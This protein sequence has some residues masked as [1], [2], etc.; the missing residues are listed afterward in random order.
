MP[1]LKNGHPVFAYRRAF[2]LIELLVVIAIIGVMIGLLLPA[3]QNARESARRMSCGNQLKQ[4]GLGIQNYHAAFQRF[5]KHGTGTGI[6][7]QV[8]Y[9]NN[10]RLS[11]LVGLLPFVEQQSL[12]E[13]ISQ[14]AVINGVQYQAMGPFT[15]S[16]NY[17]P[18]RT[19]VPTFR[20]PSDPAIEMPESWGMTNYGACVGDAIV[21]SEYGGIDRGGAVIVPEASVCLR[22]FFEPRHFTRFGDLLDGAS[23]TIA[24]GELVVDSGNRAIVEQPARWN[25]TLLDNPQSCYETWVTER[26]QFWNVA[27]DLGHPNDR[28]GRRWHECLPLY[29]TVNTIRPP[30]RESCLVGFGDDSVGTYTMASRHPGGCHVVMGDGA[31]RFIT[32]S[33]D[34]GNQS[35]GNV[36]RSNAVAGQES[37]YGVW[38]ALGTKANHEVIAVTP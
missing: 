15:W 31:V 30:N 27:T 21:Y 23:N 12:W 19:T 14:P 17:A 18:W 11:W 38:G 33:I 36:P 6:P 24:V 3:V 16:L 25:D 4:I 28:R 22:G 32:D 26:P 13:L 5:P 7:T 35:V 10:Q 37:P 1:N 34:A 20:C 9:L 8:W 2:T 29:T